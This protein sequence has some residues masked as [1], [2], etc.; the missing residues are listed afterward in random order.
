MSESNMNGVEDTLFIPLAARILA[1][2]K[3]PNFFYD[4]KSLQFD[5]LKQIKS[6][7]NKSSEY[8]MLASV[9]R[10]YVMDKIVKSFLSNNENAIIV[11]LGVDLET[12]NYRLKDYKGHFFQVDFPSV[13]KARER[14]LKK[15]I[16]KLL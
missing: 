6:I 5:N 16:T 12:M 3:Y 13:I 2:K 15:L 7:N 8:T 4:Q 1:S 10:Y 11:N 14:L 9:A